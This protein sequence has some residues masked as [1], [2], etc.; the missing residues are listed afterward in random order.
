MTNAKN[1]LILTEMVLFLLFNLSV[2][3]STKRFII[4]K[5][6]IEEKSLI[7][8]FNLFFF[9]CFGVTLMLACGMKRTNADFVLY[10]QETPVLSLITGAIAI[11]VTTILTKR[12]LK[13][14][15]KCKPSDEEHDSNDI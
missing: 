4:K 10:F 15:D 13:E 11:Y 1:V 12:R 6:N 8:I 14:S 5:P 9:I 2:I 7:V 3:L